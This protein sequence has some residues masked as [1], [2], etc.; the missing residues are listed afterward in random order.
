MTGDGW[1]ALCVDPLT[2]CTPSQTGSKGGSEAGCHAPASPSL[3]FPRSTTERNTMRHEITPSEAAA[4]RKAQAAQ[5]AKNRA[6]Q[7]R[8]DLE[9]WMSAQ[10]LRHKTQ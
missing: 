7:E 3:P 2:F 4:I 8:E 9:R 5:A 1:D 10:E 6:E